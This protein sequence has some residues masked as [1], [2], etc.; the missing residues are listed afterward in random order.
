MV[1]IVYDAADEALEGSLWQE[2]IKGLLVLFDLTESEGA[3]LVS[4]LFDATVGGG[5]LLDGLA[6]N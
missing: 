5:R 1:H 2:V 6:L 4:P 3:S